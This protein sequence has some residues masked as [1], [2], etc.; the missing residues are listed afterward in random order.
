MIFYYIT[1]NSWKNIVAI[2]KMD[3]TLEMYV[4]EL[5]IKIETIKTRL[6]VYYM[7]ENV[8]DQETM[9]YLKSKLKL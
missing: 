3:I 2:N 6:V 1:Y 4:M 8:T 5:F 9:T 7:L